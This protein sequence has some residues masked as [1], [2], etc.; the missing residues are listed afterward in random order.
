[1]KT[2]WM[3]QSWEVSLNFIH[4]AIQVSSRTRLINQSGKRIVVIA[5]NLLEPHPILPLYDYVTWAGH[6]IYFSLYF[7]GYNIAMMLV[8]NSVPVKCLYY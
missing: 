2:T 3:K 1:M 6:F 7:L 5:L 8:L 4:S